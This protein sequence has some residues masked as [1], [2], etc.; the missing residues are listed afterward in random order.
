MR[1]DREILDEL[2]IEWHGTTGFRCRCGCTKGY[3]R[4]KS[5]RSKRCRDCEAEIS[6]TANT[7]MHGTRLPLAAWV[8]VL[9]H[10]HR[11]ATSRA[12]ARR[13]SIAVS[14]AW[15]L[16]QR[17]LRWK[18]DGDERERAARVHIMRIGLRARRKRMTPSAPPRI[19]AIDRARA[20]HVH[21]ELWVAEDR[22]R[23]G[24]IGVD[25]RETD[26]HAVSDWLDG[27]LRPRGYVSLRW[28]PR[29]V[30]GLL[31]AWSRAAPTSWSEIV[32]STQ[33]IPLWRLDPWAVTATG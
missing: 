25:A 22:A 33:P 3:A 6:I 20:P 27:Q 23:C 8:H 32:H 10:R 19:K 13:W 2:W 11:I 29:W 9:Q 26:P 17:V 15:H 5:G 30:D 1:S 18:A 28:L 7:L 4:G 31:Q 14:S 21:V 12:S 24:T 16:I